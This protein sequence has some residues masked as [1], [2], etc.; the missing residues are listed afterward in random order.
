MKNVVKAV[1]GL[2]LF[3]SCISCTKKAEEA[4]AQC[5]TTLSGTFLTCYANSG[6]YDK[7]TIVTDGTTFTYSVQ[8]FTDSA[9]TSSMGAA[10]SVSGTATIG[11]AST[12]VSGAT[13]FDYTPTSGG[14]MGCGVNTTVYSIYKFNSDCTLSLGK[15]GGLSDTGCTST[16]NRHTGISTG[17]FTR[18]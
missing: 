1:L 17:K 11:S 14:S 8:S 4:A 9:C 2:G 15:Q 12:A 5:N 13:D 3:L 10:A 6:H 18:Q 7:E 16:T